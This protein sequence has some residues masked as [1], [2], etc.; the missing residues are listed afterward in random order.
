MRLLFSCQPLVPPGEIATPARC[1]RKVDFILAKG[2]LVERS[3]TESLSSSVHA[4]LARSRLPPYSD[5]ASSD[6]S[7]ILQINSLNSE[8]IKPHRYQTFGYLSSP[9]STRT[10]EYHNPGRCKNRQNLLLGV[11][12][13]RPQREVFKKE[14]ETSRNSSP[15]FRAVRERYSGAGTPRQ[16]SGSPVCWSGFFLVLIVSHT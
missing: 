15:D 12:N 3:N 14:I 16:H 5:T 11:A 1:V 7:Q 10:V 6:P 13:P 4:T 2:L 9:L 8:A